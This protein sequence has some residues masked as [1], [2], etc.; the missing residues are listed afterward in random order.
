MP[1]TEVQALQQGFPIVDPE[2]GAPTFQFIH[3]WNLLFGNEKLTNTLALNAVPN[4]RRVVAGAGLIGGGDLSDDRTFDVGAGTGLIVNA[5][6]VAIDIVAEAERIR[7]T[8]GT[9]LVAGTNVTITV[10]DPGDTITISASATPFTSEDAQDAV[11]AILT[12]TSTI[13]LTY[14]D[15][16][17]TLTANVIA[18]SIGATEL[19]A[20]AVTPGSYTNTALTVDADGRITAAS[21][22]GAAGLRPMVDG[23]NPPVFIINIDHDLVMV[24]T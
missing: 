11:G 7:D 12:D 5:D 21:S 4:E 16:A 1:R 8:I 2:T 10:D 13:N 24:A 17:N 3:L 19:A 14:D 15:A 6:D 9:T 18:G 22:G 23:S 20:T